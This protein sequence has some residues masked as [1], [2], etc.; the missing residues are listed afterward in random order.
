MYKRK[1]GRIVGG[2]VVRAH[3]P[4]TAGD[5]TSIPG[6]EPRSHM[7]C[8]AAEKNNNL[9]TVYISDSSK[10]AALRS[11]HWTLYIDIKTLTATVNLL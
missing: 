3:C 2:P 1:L 11:I 10:I 4:S 9:K 7:P 5:T 8:G 6:Q